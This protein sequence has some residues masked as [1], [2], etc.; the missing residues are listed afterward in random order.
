M[1]QFLH[2]Y[3]F[4]FLPQNSFS[5]LFNSVSFEALNL[6]ATYLMHKD[7]SF[8]AVKKQYQLAFSF[9]FIFL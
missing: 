1:S 2:S 5:P 8:T 3:F 9:L 6:S 7:F 4:L